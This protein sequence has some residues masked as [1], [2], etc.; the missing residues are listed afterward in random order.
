V[1]KDEAEK[2]LCRI[3]MSKL[4]RVCQSTE[5]WNAKEKRKH[6]EKEAKNCCLRNCR[7]LLG[8]WNQE[9]IASR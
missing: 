2:M 3:V 7:V 8:I 6:Q 4:C 9:T 5:T 1:V